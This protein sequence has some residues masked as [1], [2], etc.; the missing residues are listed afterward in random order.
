MS[1]RK[2]KE[3]DQ[4]GHKLAIQTWTQRLLWTDTCLQ[5][6]SNISAPSR[7]IYVYIY[8]YVL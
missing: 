1:G 4:M 5:H 7:Y 6:L 2:E 3:M 8:I